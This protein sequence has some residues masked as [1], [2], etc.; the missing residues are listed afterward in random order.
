LYI[1]T[2]E[3]ASL[4][5]QQTYYKDLD[6]ALN[7]YI[8]QHPSEFGK[9]SEGK[10]RK[11]GRK[12]RSPREK[13]TDDKQV[14]E[15]PPKTAIQQILGILTDMLKTMSSPKAA[16]LTLLCLVVM[17]GV[18][19]FIARKMAFVEQQLVRLG[20]PI[21][22]EDVAVDGQPSRKSA[23]LR[24]EEDDLWEWLCRVDP[25]KSNEVTEHIQVYAEKDPKEQEV[26]DDAI[27]NTKL[28]KNRLDKHM[29]ELSSMIQKAESSL[30]DITKAV[31]DQRQNI[32]NEP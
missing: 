17:V 31:H 21:L 32:K 25:D 13:T 8:K 12:S 10:R 24:Q 20:K 23:L 14:A 7:E 29:K 16:H 4:D 2:I 22:E 30:E 27:K 28:A 15:E 11:R 6:V 3:K 9:P 18:N 5:G 1:A 26:W 19:L